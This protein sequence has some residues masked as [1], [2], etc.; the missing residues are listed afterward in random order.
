M[1][2]AN[3]GGL[4]RAQLRTLALASLGGALEFY[5]FVIFVFFATTMGALFFPP[6]L[7]DWMRMVQTFGIFAAGYLARPL[8]GVVMAHFGDLGGR[9]KMFMLSILLMAIPTL[10]M[11]LLPTYA[12]VGVL[13]PILLLLLRVMQGAA[14][15]GEAPG[16]WVFVSEHVSPRHRNFACGALSAGLC[17]GILLGSLVAR[18]VNA[19]FDE[20]HL[21]AWGWR[22]PFVL[23]GVFGLLAMFLRRKLHETPVF[24]E[25]QAKR[26]LAS[27]LPLKSVLREHA[28]AVLLAMLLTWL[29]TAAVV[30]TLLMMPTLLQ[31]MGVAREDAL[32]GNTLAICATVVANLVAGWLGD[33][34]GAGRVLALCSALLGLAFCWFYLGAQAGEYSQWRYALAGIAVGLTALVPAIAV[35]GFPAPVRFSGLSF[36]YNVAYAIAG[37]LTPVLLSLAM[38]DNHAA[39]M[40]YIAGM[41]LLGVA[42][43]LFVAMRRSRAIE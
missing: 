26:A 27:E 16:A 11:G 28:G 20:A 17:A 4:T 6:D 33:R 37:G 7:P 25:L 43:G 30:V 41:S 35:G 9:K 29:L 1:D 40:H 5:D 39:P 2:A 32:A 8:G 31:G 19:E 3:T 21:L 13:A 12:Q 14:I 38:K 42:L 10:L 22:V 23:G 24:A 34:F 18:V 15:G 36:S